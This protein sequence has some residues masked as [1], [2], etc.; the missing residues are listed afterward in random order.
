MP[1]AMLNIYDD[2]FYPGGPGSSGFDAE[3]SRTFK[4]SIMEN[5]VLKNFLYDLKNAALANAETRGNCGRSGYSSP[6]SVSPSNIVAG[7]GNVSD[8]ISECKNGIYLYSALGW[9]TANSLAGDFSVSIDVG[10][11]VADGEIKNGVRGIIAGNFFEMLKKINGV[12]K[13]QERF[14]DLISPKIEFYEVG[15]VGN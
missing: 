3:G 11:K 10:F 5:G 13:K 1:L 8:L 2:P 7:S 12:E 15:V 6:V 9:H 14:Q 4:K